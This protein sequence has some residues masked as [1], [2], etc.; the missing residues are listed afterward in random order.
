MIV[1]KETP[2]LF[3]F[4]CLVLSLSVCLSGCEQPQEFRCKDTIGCIT[5]DP[6]KP[7][8][9]GVMQLLSGD[10]KASGLM[11]VRGIEL[12]LAQHNNQLL[13]H[14]LKLV[15]EDAG[16][17]AEMGINAALTLATTPKLV[18]IIGPFCS[19]SATASMPMISKAGL[20]MISGSNSAPSLTSSNGKPGKNWYAG[21]YRTMY[22]GTKMAEMAAVFTYKELGIKQ[23]ATIND[24]DSFTLELTQE[25]ERVFVEIGGKIVRTAGINKGD[26]DLTPVLQSIAFSKPGLIYFP[27]FEPDAVKIIKQAKTIP[28]LEAVKLIGSDGARSERF[29]QS[30]GSAGIGLYL[31]APHHLEHR[32]TK[33]LLA[34]YEAR[35]QEKPYHFSLPHVYDATGLLLQAIEKITVKEADGTLQI[36]R[37]ALRDALYQTSNYDGITGRLSCDAFGDFFGGTYTMIQLEDLEGGMAGFDANIKFRYH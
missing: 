7:I 24:G 19:I 9:I 32:D 8:A 37:Q 5:I 36:G 13:G 4:L 35:F 33:K 10:L 21:Y 25:F 11:Q 34:D 1:R 14:P 26:R 3:V 28:G 16:C 30:I 12:G 31:T 18:G 22:N 23:A 27:L 29:L 2:Q 20:V 15:V 6:E 17:S